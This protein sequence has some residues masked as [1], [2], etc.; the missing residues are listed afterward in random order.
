MYLIS[1]SYEDLGYHRINIYDLKH[2]KNRP[3]TKMVSTQSINEK[4]II[5][6]DLKFYKNV[7]TEFS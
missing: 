5:I 1:L 7:K 2:L 3:H 4:F 6:V